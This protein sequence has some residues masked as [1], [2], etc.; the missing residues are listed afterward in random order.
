MNSS[1][2][3]KENRG[4]I[5]QT[6]GCRAEGV[7]G[8]LKRE[9]GISR[10]KLLHIGWIHS[11]APL[12]G[13]GNND[14]PMVNHNGRELLE[15]CAHIYVYEELTHWK[16]PWCW[17]RSGARDEGG[18]RGWDGWMASPTPW[19]RVWASSGRWWRAEEPGVLHFPGSQR[20][21]HDLAT[22]QQRW[23]DVSK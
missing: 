5:E 9:V 10:R 16:R 8:G 19:T 14:K 1:L 2:K 4:H 18:N 23:Q 21:G 15:H 3:Q 13:A 11:K 20:V 22:E 6:G 7:G 12:Y 17:E